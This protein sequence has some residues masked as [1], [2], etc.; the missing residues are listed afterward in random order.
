MRW[1]CNLWLKDR[2]L[3]LK[4]L[5][6]GRFLFY[7]LLI[8][9]SIWR[10]WRYG[11]HALLRFLSFR[12]LLLFELWWKINVSRLL[13]YASLNESLL[14]SYYLRGSFN[15]VLLEMM[16]FSLMAIK[17]VRFHL[18]F[19]LQLLNLLFFF[20]VLS[21]IK[22]KLLTDILSLIYHLLEEALESSDQGLS[23]HYL[24]LLIHIHS[25]RCHASLPSFELL[26]YHSH[27]LPEC[28]HWTRFLLCWFIT[29]L[30]LLK[31]I[32]EKW[33]LD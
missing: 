10:W 6:L 24:F 7:R 22:L 23:I 21:L 5:L 27:S 31:H 28:I 15:Y 32:L 18:S 20:F 2:H 11:Y 19:L 17:I 12:R 26:S 14:L 4:W 29:L 8:W 16:F 30:W 13:N 25:F 9:L 33:T 3:R 1:W